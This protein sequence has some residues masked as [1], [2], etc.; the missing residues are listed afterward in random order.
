MTADI[1]RFIFI[2][3]PGIVTLFVFEEIHGK[4]DK[5]GWQDIIKIFLAS[6]INYTILNLIIGED[7]NILMLFTFN[8]KSQSA[9]AIKQL[10]SFFT[11]QNANVIFSE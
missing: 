7:L 4:S 8:L 5:R 6:T 2:A 11:F 1:L 9:I 10:Y 3:I